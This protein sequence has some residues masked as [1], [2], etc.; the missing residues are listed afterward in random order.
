LLR[1]ENATEFSIYINYVYDADAGA[2]HDE[3]LRQL[4][5]LL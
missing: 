3:A 2:V 4:E 1:E 5:N